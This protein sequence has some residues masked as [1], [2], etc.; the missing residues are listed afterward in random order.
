M[1]FKKA[2]KLTFKKKAAKI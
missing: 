1:K 2:F